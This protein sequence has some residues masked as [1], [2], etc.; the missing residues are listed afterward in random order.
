MRCRC[1]ITCNGEGGGKREAKVRELYDPV[2]G[3]RRPSRHSFATP[4][5]T[6]D[7]APPRKSQPLMPVKDSRKNAVP[8]PHPEEEAPV[9]KKAKVAA[10]KVP[11]HDHD[12]PPIRHYISRRLT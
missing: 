5:T 8:A 9:A 1:Y 4:V 6:D 11:C 3:V 12:T 10:P 2:A 7:T